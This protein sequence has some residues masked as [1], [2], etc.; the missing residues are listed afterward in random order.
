[1]SAVRAWRE[2]R[3]RGPNRED[4]EGLDTGQGRGSTGRPLLYVKRYISLL[5]SA[6]I[7][8]RGRL[9]AYGDGGGGGLM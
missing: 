6:R 4:W 9:P 3:G 5:S 2:G 8:D 7:G 1:M